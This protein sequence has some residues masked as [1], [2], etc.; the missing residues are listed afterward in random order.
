VVAIEVVPQGG[1]ATGTSAAGSSAT[2]NSGTGGSTGSS[3]GSD[4]A[5]RVT[6]RLDDG[7]T[8]VVTQETTPAF[9]SGDRV[10][11]AGGLI[12]R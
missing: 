11:L 5:Y 9:R 12:Q 1:A 4:R 2:G 10:A 7:S 3:S 8:A 6:L